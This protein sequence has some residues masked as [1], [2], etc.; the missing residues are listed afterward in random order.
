VLGE[1]AS[2]RVGLRDLERDQRSCPPTQT[3]SLRISAAEV[4]IP[5]QVLVQQTLAATV[6][7]SH[8][9]SGAIRWPVDIGGDNMIPP[10]LPGK[11][12]AAIEVSKEVR[13][14][15]VAKN[16]RVVLYDGGSNDGAGDKVDKGKTC[17]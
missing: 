3:K 17:N 11:R 9:G 1:R 5:R 6:P 2:G 7:D 12:S 8:F 14:H 10:S 4:V 13:P 15:K 16:V